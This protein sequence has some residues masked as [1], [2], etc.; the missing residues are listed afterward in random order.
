MIGIWQA[1][2][3]ACPIVAGIMLLIASSVPLLVVP[4]S[5]VRF[6]RWEVHRPDSW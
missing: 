4:I 5:W 6:M 1:Y 3:G 2:A